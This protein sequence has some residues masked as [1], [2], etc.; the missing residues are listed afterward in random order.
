MKELSPQEWLKLSAELGPL[1]PMTHPIQS[2]RLAWG[3]TGMM[4]GFV[5]FWI[6]LAGLLLVVS[7]LALDAVKG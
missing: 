5:G 7:A 6:G 3:S 2:F 1:A 4:V